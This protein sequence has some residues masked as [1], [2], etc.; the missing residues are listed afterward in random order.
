MRHKLAVKRGN[1]QE[2]FISL[3]LL[4]DNNSSVN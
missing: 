4:K 2:L 1:H 3:P